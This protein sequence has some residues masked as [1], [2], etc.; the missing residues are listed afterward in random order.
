MLIKFTSSFFH[1]RFGKIASIK[2]S[3]VNLYNN[4]GIFLGA[5]MIVFLK[6]YHSIFKNLSFA[7]T[8]FEQY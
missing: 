1:P 3:L 2:I 4:Q 7:C 6:N 8:F 5:E